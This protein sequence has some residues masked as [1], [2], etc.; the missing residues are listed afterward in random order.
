MIRTRVAVACACALAIGAF[1]AR[2]APVPDH[3][4]PK[5]EPLFHSVR[6]GDTFVY[7]H[8]DTEYTATIASA[9]RTRDGYKV[10]QLGEHNTKYKMTMLVTPTGVRKV[11]HDDREIEEPR[12]WLRVPHV[13]NNKWVSV[14]CQFETAGWE[15]LMLPYG[16]VRALRVNRTL[17]DAKGT[18]AVYYWAHRLGLVKWASGEDGWELKSFTPG[19]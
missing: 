1:G 18:R 7:V 15:D 12:E 19:K 5:E 16:K 4:M 10:V 17:G 13:A 2:A 11:A 6:A 14:T 8:K 9:E 3:L